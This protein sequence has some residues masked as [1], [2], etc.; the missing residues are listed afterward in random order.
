MP[1]KPAKTT[2]RAQAKATIAAA[3]ARGGDNPAEAALQ[4]FDDAARG[5]SN[6]SQGDASYGDALRIKENYQALLRQLEYSTKSGAV[7][8]TATDSAATATPVS[9]GATQ[10]SQQT[11][12]VRLGLRTRRAAHFAYRFSGGRGRDRSTRS[13]DYRV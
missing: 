3:S 2:A 10:P 6:G 11:M 12:V 1:H 8:D 4:L 7:A 5:G 13:D 9:S